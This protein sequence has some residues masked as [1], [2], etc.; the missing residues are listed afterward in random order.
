MIPDDIELAQEMIPISI[1]IVILFSILTIAAIF[2]RMYTLL[3]FTGFI[4][5]IMLYVLINGLYL[6]SKH[7][8][9]AK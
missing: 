2:M 3:L 1:F 5:I 6:I 4:L 9:Q 8:K 7:Q